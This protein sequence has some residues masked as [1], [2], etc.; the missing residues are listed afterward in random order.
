MDVNGEVTGINTA[1][2]TGNGAGGNQEVGFAI[3]VNM[4]RQ[5]MDQ[6][7]KSGHVVRG[8]LGAWIQPV[9]PEIAKA[10]CVAEAGGALLGDVDPKGLAGMSDLRRGD[11]VLE[12]RLRPPDSLADSGATAQPG[13]F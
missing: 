13:R 2:L 4:A 8:Y 11:M 12:E 6:I 5:V 3:P 7:L 9:T 10:F 1:I